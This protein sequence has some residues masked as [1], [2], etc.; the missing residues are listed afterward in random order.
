MGIPYFSNFPLVD[1]SNKKARNLALKTV[2]KERVKKRNIS[3]LFYT[4][5]DGERPDTI[6]NDYY[7]DSKL[8]WLVMLSND[9]IDPYFEWHLSQTQLDAHLISKYGSLALAGSTVL[10]YEKPAEVLYTDIA[11]GLLFLTQTELDLLTDQSGWK[12]SIP[13]DVTRISKDAYEN[14]DLAP[15]QDLTGF[16]AVFALDHE[17]ELNES[18]RDIRLIRREFLPVILRDLKELL[19]VGIATRS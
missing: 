13:G 6:A 7:G 14:S 15:L 18:R 4:L 2:I 1:Y 8:N 12:A 10:W 19:D 3:F 17:E 16:S 11:T 9:I 5:R